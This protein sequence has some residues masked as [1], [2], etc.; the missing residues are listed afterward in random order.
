M[1]RVGVV[2]ALALAG[3]VAAWSVL[4]YTAHR[5]RGQLPVLGDV[6]QFSLLASSDEP[7]SQEQLAGKIW[8]ADFIFTKCHGICPVLS[9]QMARLQARL[10]EASSNR[11]RLV[12]FSVDPKNDTPAVLR[13]YAQRFD[14]DTKQ[15]MFLTGER[16]RLHS[17]IHDG[18]RLAVAER[19]EDE[20]A[21]AGD[22]DEGLITH[23]DRFVLVDGNMRIRG[24][25][26]GTDADSVDQVLRDIDELQAESAG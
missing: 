4:A 23:S 6:P 1:R 26:H 22:A 10:G 20:A 24:Y 8:V 3:I 7:F 25:Y 16:A 21:A 17:L 19:S 5:G 13:D 14:A 9:A 11:V 15:W 12:S 18:F 2:S